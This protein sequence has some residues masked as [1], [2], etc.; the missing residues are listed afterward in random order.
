MGLKHEECM[1]IL[2]DTTLTLHGRRVNRAGRS[3]AGLPRC[4]SDQAGHDQGLA[5]RGPVLRSQPGDEEPY[6]GPRV[7]VRHGLEFV[8]V[9]AA[10]AH[11]VSVV[12]EPAHLLRRLDVG[13][14]VLGGH[15]ILE[16][17]GFLRALETLRFNRGRSGRNA[18][19]PEDG[20]GRSWKPSEPPVGSQTHVSQFDRLVR[21]S[22]EFVPDY[23]HTT[24]RCATR[25]HLESRFRGGVSVAQA[26]P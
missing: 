21:V 5:A 13:E 3:V 14:V 9:A 1:Q 12:D 23:G 20:H 19:Q 16:V 22:N 26:R 15:A 10:E 6:L 4:R 11:Q 8:S 17:E 25:A 2:V 18:D 7:W 24:V